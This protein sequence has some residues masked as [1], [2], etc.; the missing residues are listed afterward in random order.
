V[1]TCSYCGAGTDDT[2]SVCSQCGGTFSSSASQREFKLR[3][4]YL[5]PVSRF[6]VILVVGLISYLLNIA[7]AWVF[8]RDLPVDTANAVAWAG[9]G[10]VLALPPVVY[11]ATVALW[12]A[13]TIGVY[14]FIPG[15]RLLYAFLVGFTMFTALVGGVGVCLPAEAFLLYVSSMSDGAVLV[16]AFWSPLRK[17]FQG[18]SAE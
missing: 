8:W 3:H 10:A 2:A 9:F 12:I 1:R 5:D 18:A 4:L 15:A 16:L 7:G 14:F 6:R 17:R 13:A 11:W